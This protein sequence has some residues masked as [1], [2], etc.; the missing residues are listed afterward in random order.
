MISSILSYA[1][2]S[3]EVL[4]PR[5]HQFSKQD[6]Q[7]HAQHPQFSNQIDASDLIQSSDL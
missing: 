1:P 2:L 3:V 7:D 6:P 4:G 5:H